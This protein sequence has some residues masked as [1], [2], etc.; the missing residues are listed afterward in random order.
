ML[1]TIAALIIILGGALI[2]R[3]ARGADAA[4]NRNLGSMSEHWLADH[5]ASQRA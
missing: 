1:F 4:R 5:N 3:K 2:I